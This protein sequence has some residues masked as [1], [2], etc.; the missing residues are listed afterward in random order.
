[1]NKLGQLWNKLRSSLWFVPVLMVTCAVALA[2]SIIEIDTRLNREPFITWPRLF[3]A[4]AEGSRGMLSAIASSMITV[5]G[6]TFSI[7]IV[8]LSLASSQYTPR[9]L[10]SFMRDRT[11]QI[12]LGF[13][14]GIFAYCLVVLRTIRGKEEGSFIPQL[15]VAF[16]FVLALIGIGVLIL[17]IH[18]IASSIQASNVISSAAAETIKAV[19]KLFPTELGEEA[20]EIE[21]DEYEYESSIKWEAIPALKTG[22][23]QGV[24]TEEMLRFAEKHGVV[25]RMEHGIGEFVVKDSPL[26]S[27]S[28]K[29][30]PNDK[31]VGELNGIYSISRNRT[32]EQDAMFGITQIVDI[33]LKALSTGINDTTTALTCVDYLGAILAELADRRIETRCRTSGGRLSV[34]ARG[35]SFA[36]LVS[37]SFDQIRL[38]AMGNVAMLTRILGTI[39]TIAGRT[40]NGHRRSI[41]LQHVH[42]IVAAADRSVNLSYDRDQVRESVERAL[43]RLDE[44]PQDHGLSLTRKDV[45]QWH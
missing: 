20:D 25:L 39:E 14:V 15:A 12:V 1:M 17:F 41:L 6:V 33:A 31:L 18:H 37:A 27:L 28:I 23:I 16:G 43:A 5:A 19:G 29:S 26:A 42:L 34:I 7:T 44:N 40:K 10:R 45:E 36:G 35:P 8:A 38:N 11:N 2:A 3:G 9:I 21:E 24:D 4:G 30:S 22:Y 32:V 13:F